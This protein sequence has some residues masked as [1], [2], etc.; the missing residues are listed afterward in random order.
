MYPKYSSIEIMRAFSRFEQKIINKLIELDGKKGS[1]VNLANVIDL[2]YSDGIPDYYFIQVNSSNDVVL[3]IKDTEIACDE[4]RKMQDAEDNVSKV[5]IPTVL[6]FEHLEVNGFAYFTGN[7]N[8]SSIGDESS[9]EKYTRCDFLDDEIKK[10]IY[11]Y[12]KKRIYLTE[13]LRVFVSNGFKNE[14]DLRHE[15]ELD[16]TNSQLNVTRLALLV[17]FLGL[18]ASIFVPISSTSAVRLVN[19]TAALDVYVNELGS[20]SNTSNNNVDVSDEPIDET[21]Q[22]VSAA[23]NGDKDPE[24]E[25]KTSSE[26]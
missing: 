2:L 13:S 7:L 8:F 11:K 25:D 20:T 24:K 5:V 1:L 22:D 16:A 21:V 6:L 9:D 4:L 26:S 17:T 14:D 10:L 18:L 19:E 3:Q 15:R 23:S 12:T